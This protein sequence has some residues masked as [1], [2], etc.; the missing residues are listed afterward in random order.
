MYISSWLVFSHRTKQMVVSFQPFN[1][2]KPVEIVKV[3]N[4]A[5]R[6]VKMYPL[7]SKGFCQPPQL[8]TFDTEADSQ[9]HKN[10]IFLFE[11]S[12]FETL[13][14]V[15]PPHHQNVFCVCLA[16]NFTMDIWCA[17]CSFGIFQGLKHR[18]IIITDVKEGIH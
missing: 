1:T 3:K 14:F 13:S 5:S 17:V 2:G 7:S 16:H 4:P 6:I 11:S 9:E 10:M 12:S 8:C 18:S 15:K